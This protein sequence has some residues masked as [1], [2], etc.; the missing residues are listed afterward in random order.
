MPKY[1]LKWLVDSHINILDFLF[2]MRP[3]SLWQN[4]LLWAYTGSIDYSWLHQCPWHK[5]VTSASCVSWGSWFACY[6]R[7]REVSSLLQVHVAHKQLVLPCWWDYLHWVRLSLFLCI[8]GYLSGHMNRVLNWSH[9]GLCSKHVARLHSYENWTRES[10]VY[11]FIRT[12]IE[13]ILYDGIV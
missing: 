12:T 10:Y 6:F 13:L 4:F 3:C 11:K 5:F 7:A 1:I 2:W 8:W 9:H